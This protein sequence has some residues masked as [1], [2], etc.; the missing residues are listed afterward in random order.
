MVDE[1]DD[2]DLDEIDGTR[3]RFPRWVRRGASQ[4]RWERAACDRLLADMGTVLQYR[5]K[6]AE[7]LDLC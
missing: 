2:D 3:S 4:N 5:D 7:V 1:E 6:L